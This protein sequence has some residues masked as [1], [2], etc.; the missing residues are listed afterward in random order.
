MVAAPANNAA[1]SHQ[2]AWQCFEEE[3]K[4]AT[5]KARVHRRD[6][7]WSAE[8]TVAKNDFQY[9]VCLSVHARFCT[10]CT[11]SSSAVTTATAMTTAADAA[12]FLAG[13][14]SS[15]RP[16]RRH[17]KFY[18]PSST[19][20]PS[21]KRSQRRWVGMF[22]HW[23]QGLFGMAASSNLNTHTRKMMSCR[24]DADALCAMSCRQRRTRGRRLR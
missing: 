20:K 15:A 10:H 23:Q 19:M 12:A 18:W 2:Q 1:V 14:V 22:A 21:S 8:V 24:S 7:G 13:V 4:L 11:G 16:R 6:G 3:N 5:V 9:V 17:R